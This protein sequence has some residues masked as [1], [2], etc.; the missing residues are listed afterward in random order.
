MPINMTRHFRLILFGLSVLEI[1]THDYGPHNERL[2][3]KIQSGLNE[4]Y[5]RNAFNSTYN[6]SL[7]VAGN[8]LGP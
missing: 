2:V 3:A 6:Y 7:E 8:C 1:S 4:A 5:R